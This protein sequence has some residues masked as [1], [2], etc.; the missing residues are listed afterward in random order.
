MRSTAE[1]ENWEII[2]HR[3]DTLG[4]AVSSSKLHINVA[5]VLFK[6]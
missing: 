5:L 4:D 6:Q 1:T 3:V 2:G